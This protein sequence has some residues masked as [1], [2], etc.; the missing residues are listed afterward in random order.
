MAKELGESLTDDE[1]RA[2]IDEFDLDE[3]GES[4]WFF[5]PSFTNP[6]QRG[7][8]YKY[9][10]GKLM[11]Y[12]LFVGCY[13]RRSVQPIFYNKNLIGNNTILLCKIN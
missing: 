4:E 10:Y 7:G 2:M 6:S 12:M 5:R 9:L 13:L 8:V 11:Y 3:D 1:L